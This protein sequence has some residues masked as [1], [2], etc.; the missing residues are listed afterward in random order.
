MATEV[1]LLEVDEGDQDAASLS[2][3][4][5][6]ANLRAALERAGGCRR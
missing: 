5:A 1:L 6:F 4:P 3:V 2:P